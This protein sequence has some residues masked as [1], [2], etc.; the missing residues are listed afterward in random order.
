MGLWP[1]CDPP[2]VMKNASVRQ[3]RLDETV[4][5]PFVI[6]TE[7]KRSGG[8]C[9]S[10][11]LS[12]KCFRPERTRISC[13][14]ALDKAACAAFIKESRIKFT[15]ATNLNRKPGVAQW[16]DLRFLFDPSSS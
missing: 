1:A 6:P 16:R 3:P 13:H 9:S 8:I 15:N 12:W 7:A 2:K 4:A 11:D 14:A 5:L 10:T